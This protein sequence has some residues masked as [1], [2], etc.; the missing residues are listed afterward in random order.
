MNATVPI[1]TMDGFCSGFKIKIESGE[2]PKPSSKRAKHGDEYDSPYDFDSLKP[3]L[4]EFVPDNR[5]RV[6]RSLAT[7]V[8]KHI[9]SMGGG[10]R[11]Q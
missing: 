3:P 9:N 6:A 10:G 4:Q 5:G 1:I 7:Y 8:G 2:D 11:F